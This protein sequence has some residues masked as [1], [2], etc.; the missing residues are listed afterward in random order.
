MDKP[1][2]PPSSSATPG[3]PEVPTAV[4]G[5]EAK[6]ERIALMRHELAELQRQLIDVQQKIA[7]ELQGRAEDADRFEELEA[8]LKEQEDK[9]RE[10]AARIAAIGAER[11][12]LRARLESAGKT[13]EELRRELEARSARIEE[14]G[15]KHRE[16]SEQLDSHVASLRDTKS[17]L[18]ARDAELAT[19]L[20]E[21][22]TEQAT[23]ARLE[24]ELEASLGKQ[25]ELT[26]QLETGASSLREAQA[27]L[28]ARDAELATRTSERDAQQEA[29]LHLEGE[30]EKT[31]RALDGGRARLQ[32]LAEQIFS[33]GQGM[34]DAAATGEPRG[35]PE[36]SVE[37]PDV[38]GAPAQPPRVG[39][40]VGDEQPA[41]AA[42]G[43][44]AQPEA[45]ADAGASGAALSAG[46]L[47][48]GIIVL[49]PEA[50]GHRIFV[51]GHQVQPKNRRVD[52]P[53][54]KHQVQIGSRSEP[55]VLDVACDGETELR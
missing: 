1:D 22:D 19:R 53:C 9:A 48:A 49:P 6:T 4:E 14:A 12:D 5:G 10:D 44:I 20:A 35:A 45:T 52:V 23:R 41:A 38:A 30:L 34:L 8:R 11:S 32:K 46:A 26:E 18:A 24:R 21:R 28:A 42:A 39:E 40:P 29:R 55:Q 54:G 2:G 13:A 36:T 25:R 33:V 31:Q 17:Q 43:A 27:Q 15:R 37:A 51:D 7:A 3:A 16:L 50:D 47:R